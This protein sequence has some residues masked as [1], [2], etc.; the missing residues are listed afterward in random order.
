MLQSVLL[1]TGGLKPAIVRENAVLHVGA[2]LLLSLGYQARVQGRLGSRLL[3]VRFSDLPAAARA[4]VYVLMIAAVVV[5]DRE[6][7]PFVYFQF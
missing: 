7:T 4:A 5:F 2:V 3:S 6:A 1:L